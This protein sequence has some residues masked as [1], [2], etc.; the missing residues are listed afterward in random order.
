[1]HRKIPFTDSQHKLGVIKG[2][3]EHYY[4]SLLIQRLKHVHVFYPSMVV[5][6]GF[7]YVFAMLC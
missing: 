2:I 1:M 5:P 6:L 7:S 4:K 3:R